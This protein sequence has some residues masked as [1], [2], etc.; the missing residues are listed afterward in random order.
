[1]SDSPEKRALPD[2]TICAVDTRLPSLAYDAIRRSQTH[3][4]F[5]AA[6]LLTSEGW[7]PPAESG[8]R[9]EI[10]GIPEIKSSAAYS[11]FMLK[12]LP[13]FIKT[14]HVLVVQWDGFVAHPDLWSDEFLEFDYVGAVWPQYKDNFRVGN[15]GF[16]LRSAKL[17]NVLAADSFQ[18]AHPEDVYICRT[19]RNELETRHG[20]RFAPEELANAFAVERCGH[21]A[22]AFGFHGLTN[23]FNA[24]PPQELPP[25]FSQLPPG[26]FATTEA[27]GAIKFLARRGEQQ[28]ARLALESRIHQQGWTPGN[29][30]LATHLGWW[31]LAQPRRV[32]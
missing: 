22:Q 3:L 28:L 23:L 18:G 13:R 31:R 12:E 4:S 17:I 11:A 32:N 10:I 1:M 15:G 2:V 7:R 6:L 16:S 24:L 26:V 19:V 8:Q 27:R 5:G 30:R 20:I 29:I 9:I 21:L 14:R 25:L